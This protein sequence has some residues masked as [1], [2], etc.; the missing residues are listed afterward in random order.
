MQPKI[1]VIVP[2]YKAEKYLRRCVDSILSQTFTDFEVLLID[3]GS[4]DKSGVICD[5][6]ASKD[7][8]V[9]VFHKD[10]GGVS[11]ARNLGLDNAQGEYTIHVDPDD[12]VE[13]NMLEDLYAKAKEEDA[14]IVI[15]DYYIN[16]EKNK[17]EIYVKQQPSK[18]DS[19]TVL[20]ELFKHLHGSCCNKLIRLAC[21][22]I[23]NIR[24]PL[25]LNCNEDQYVC[26]SLF[27]QALN[28]SYLST[29]FYHYT[30]DVNINSLVRKPKSYDE[31]LEVMTMFCSLLQNHKFYNYCY[32]F[33]VSDL[34]CNVFWNKSYT[35]KEFKDK[36][37]KYR[38]I[39][40]LNKNIPICFRLELYLSCIGLYSPIVNLRKKLHKFI[41]YYAK[42]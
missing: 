35:S 33:M 23:H 42:N 18:L 39:I 32:Q 40:L 17:K 2:I 4:P 9:R 19:D 31:R 30:Q 24:F 16:Y 41:N 29:A 12:W 38:K 8:R 28:V 26:A 36:M 20:K 6:Y 25:N 37:Y 22:K 3:D 10:N 11:S 7:S 5:E 14:D 13:P 1:S 15:C 27:L 21:Y 34:V